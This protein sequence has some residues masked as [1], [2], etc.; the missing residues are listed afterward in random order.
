MNQRLNMR[1]GPA[2]LLAGVAIALVACSA[3][4]GASPGGPAITSPRASSSQKSPGTAASASPSVPAA[5][6]AGAAGPTTSVTAAPAAATATPPGSAAGTASPAAAEVTETDNGKTL[7][8]QVGSDVK[9]V[10]HNTYW[11]VLG[12]SNP[13]VLSLVS[14]PTYSGAGPIACI[15]GS[16]CGTVTAIFRAVAPGRAIVTA[17]RTTCGEVLPCP[18]SAGSYEVT[19]VVEG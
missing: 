4:G 12:S 10:L 1:T 17:S 18:S 16:G 19:I 14:G 8:T 11:Q 5:S 6:D 3:G 15:P 2:G 13:A 7:V 9:L